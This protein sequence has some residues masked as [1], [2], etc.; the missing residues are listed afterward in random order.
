MSYLTSNAINLYPAALRGGTDIS[1]QV[2]DPESRLGTEFNLTN[3]VNRVTID[4]SFVISYSGNILEFSIHGY[5]FRVK[6]VSNLISGF[7]SSSNIYAN[8]RIKELA[9][10]N[11]KLRSLV[12][13]ED[14]SSTNLD[15]TTGGIS[16]FK[17]VSFSTSEEGDNIN[18][19]S[20]EVLRKVN[21]S[22]VVPDT[23]LL[24]FDTKSI[25]IDNTRSDNATDL[26]EV[27]YKNGQN[28][29]IVEADKFIGNLQGN[30]TGDLYGN[31]NT[32]TESTYASKIGTVSLHPQIGGDLKPIYINSNGQV[33][34][35]NGT[36]GSYN[37]PV[38]ITGGTLTPAFKVTISQSAPTITGNEQEGDIWFQYIG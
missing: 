29:I 14:G 12:C 31:A 26:G 33:A 19:F 13:Y 2:F 38:Y 32:A 30:V 17:G 25:M 11:Y 24:K 36:T 10:D 20:L 23:S 27:V 21:N 9:Q 7:T 4:G 6:S 34:P 28:Q 15:V 18:T 35:S 16:E 8:I 37:Q 5:Y 3:P 22:W 1:G